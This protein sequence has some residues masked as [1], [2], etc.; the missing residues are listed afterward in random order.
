MVSNIWAL[1][2]HMADK[3][4]SLVNSK[5]ISLEERALKTEEISCYKYIS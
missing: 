3:N 4:E 2:G 1:K 5:L